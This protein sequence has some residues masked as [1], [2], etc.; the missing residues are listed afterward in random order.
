MPDKRVTTYSCAFALAAAA[1][2]SCEAP[3]TKSVFD[4]GDCILHAYY[5]SGVGGCS[6]TL[7]KDS[8]CQWHAGF[9][10]PQKGFYSISD[11]LIT[12]K[13]VEQGGALK[14][15]RLLITKKNPHQSQR[16]NEIL[17]QVDRADTI[18]DSIFILTVDKDI[19]ADVK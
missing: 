17:L 1:L 15:K 2:G 13:G 10:E 18:A 9:D 3:E 5:D 16:G 14:A 6:L 11:S 12:L 8:T 19:R 7:W 4:D